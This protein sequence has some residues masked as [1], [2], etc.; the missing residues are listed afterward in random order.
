[1]NLFVKKWKRLL[2][3]ALF[4][5]LIISS[6]SCSSN[7]SDDKDKEVKINVMSYNMKFENITGGG[8]PIYTWKN[9]LPGIVKSFSDYDVHFAGTQELQKWQYDQLLE[10]LGDNYQGVGEA[11]FTASDEHSAIVYRSDLFEYVEG[12]TIWLSETP[13]VRGSKSWNT[14]HPRI[15]T[16]G[17]FKHKAT[18]AEFYFFNT[19]LDHKSNLARQ[20]GLELIVNYMLEVT[21]Y[22]IILTGDFNMYYDSEDFAAI[23]EQDDIFSDTFTPFSSKF[24]PNGKT[25]HGYNGGIEGKPIDFIFYTKASMEL[26]DTDIIRDRYE[27][28]YYLSDHYPV[29]S[30]FKLI[31]ET[32]GDL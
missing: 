8:D 9:R 31:L 23:K 29:Y 3:M 32:E 11:R 16:Y 21:D 18:N 28:R 4:P 2:L 5:I 7:S 26:L 19:H 6:Y 22:P 24:E 17:K 13:N 15:L 30:K 14:A 27:D 20:K 10:K 25:S 1:M 12:E